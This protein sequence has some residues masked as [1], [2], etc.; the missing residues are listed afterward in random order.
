M[1]SE[2]HLWNK[3]YLCLRQPTPMVDVDSRDKAESVLRNQLDAV[4]ADPLFPVEDPFDLIPLLPDGKDTVFEVGDVCIPARD[5]GVKYSKYQ[6][7]PYDT[8]E[9]LIDDII[10]GVKEEGDLYHSTDDYEYSETIQL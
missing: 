10:V 5:L 6:E 7:F 9:E 4:F 3:V 1:S 8:S 2:N